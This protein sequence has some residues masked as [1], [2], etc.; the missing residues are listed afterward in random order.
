MSVR[1]HSQPYRN[2]LGRP[3]TR[4]KL[5]APATASGLKPRSDAKAK[6]CTE[7]ITPPPAP[8]AITVATSQNALVRIASPSVQS[9]AEEAATGAC[10]EPAGLGAGSLSPSGRS[11]ISSGR[12]LL[13]MPL[14]G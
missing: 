10:G 9:A 13:I 14:V 6:P 3:I 12:L 11:P 1:S 7:K 2:R 4:E 5:I 8:M